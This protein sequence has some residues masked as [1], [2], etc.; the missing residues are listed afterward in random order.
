MRRVSYGRCYE[1]LTGGGRRFLTLAQPGAE[2]K[3]LRMKAKTKKSELT[4]NAIIDAG[5]EIALAHGLGAVTVP[6]LADKLQLSTSGVFARI[7]SVEALRIAIVDEYGRRFLAEIFF[8]ALKRPRGIERLNAVVERWVEKICTN[9]RNNM[10]LYEV[11]AFAMDQAAQDTREVVIGNVRAW[12]GVMMRTV[13]QAIEHHQLR[14][15]TDPELLL[16]S[17]HSLVLGA[18]YEFRIMN[19]ANTAQKTMEAYQ[20]LIKRFSVDPQ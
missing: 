17:I 16:F 19:D 13:K 4:R 12:R 14:P 3:L 8:P 5:I 7:G 10:T 20:S 6:G 2:I 15:D 11:T 1:A 18:L 9:E